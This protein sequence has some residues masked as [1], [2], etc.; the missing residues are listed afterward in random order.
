MSRILFLANHD[1]VIYNLRLELV[2]RLIKEGH[3]IIICCPKGKRVQ[4]LIALGCKYRDVNIDRHGTNPFRDIKLI[5]IYKKLLD[6]E[7]PDCVFSYTIK[8]NIYGSLACKSRKIPC[9][10][11]VTG[12]GTAVENKGIM[13]RIAVT[14]YKI[15]F[16]KVQT[17]FFQN[18]E[19]MSFFVRKRIYPE[20]HK[21]L[22]GSGVNLQKFMPLEYP[23]GETVRF[24]FISRIMKEKGINQ[25]LEAAEN[26]KPQYPNTEFHVCGFCEQDYEERLKELQDKGVIKY[27]GNINDVAK[28]LK[29]INCVVHPTYYPE[30][31]SNILLESCAC[32]RPI[33]TTDRAGCREI[34]DDG[35]NGYVVKQKDSLDLIDKIEKFLSL[36][37]EEQKNMGLAGRKKV[38]EKFNREIVIEKYLEELR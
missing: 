30:G 26:I 23:Q 10:V 38:E 16:K 4:E 3:E 11:N 12:L 33:I 35:I 6:S 17:I 37:Y 31:M 21:L 20:K 36:S 24:A 32:A 14:L 22:P 2:E 15:A 34:V 29:D 9:V 7:K 13:Q 18:E 1:M 25:Y 19:N 8:P 5:R 27:H 28:F